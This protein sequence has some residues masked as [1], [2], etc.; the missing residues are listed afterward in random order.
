DGDRRC[1]LLHR[2][3]GA[4]IRDD[5]IGVEPG[6]FG[7]EL[8][9]ALRASFRPTILDRDGASLDPAEFTQSRCKSSG[10]W[11]PGRGVGAY[12]PDH[13]QLARLLRARRKRPSRR[14]AAEQRYERAPP[15]HSITSS[16]S[17]STLSE[18]LTPSAFA[19]LR[20]ITNSNLLDCMT[21]KSAGVA[22][23]R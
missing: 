18:N 10:P 17:D 22:P 2:W 13:G 9:G 7:G 20:L 15:H 6:E 5:N 16:A 8:R 23:L 21:A 3:R 1:C 14:R 12:D 11:P 19:V 4:G